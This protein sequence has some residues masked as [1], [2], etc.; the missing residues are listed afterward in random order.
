M[1]PGTDETF[2][3]LQSRRPGG[4]KS[5]PPESPVQIDRKIFLKSLKT[6]PEHLRVLLDEVATF[7]LLLEAASSLAQAKLPVEIATVLTGARLTALAKPD[8]GVRGIATGCSTLAKQFA[9]DFETECAPFQY[10]LLTRAGTDCVG[11]MLRAATD[12]DVKRGRDRCVRSHLKVGNAGKIEQNAKSTGHSPICAPLVWSP[13]NVQ[14][15]GS[16]WSQTCSEPGRRRRARGPADAFAVQH[17]HPG[18]S[19]RGCWHS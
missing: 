6:A 7:D 11:H 18:R 8:G 16:E 19:G 14:L 4:A 13:V 1:A 15:V 17:W 12:S 3:A 2:R 10:D 5:H 9:K